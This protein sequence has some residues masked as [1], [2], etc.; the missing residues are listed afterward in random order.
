MTIRYADRV[1]QTSATTGT[2]AYLLG[3]VMPGGYR[4][5]DDVPGIVDGD[6][7]YASID[8]EYSDEYEVGLYT[9][10]DSGFLE[11][12][13]IMASSRDGLPVPWP[14]GATR[15]ISLTLTAS[16]ID[17]STLQYV[18]ASVSSDR[19]LALRGGVFVLVDPPTGG[20]GD[21]AVPGAPIIGTAQAGNATVSIYFSAPVSNGGSA[22]LD[23]RAYLSDGTEVVGS[24]SPIV[25]TGKIN[26]QPYTGYVRARNALGMGPASATSNTVTPQSTA[27]VPT[28][29]TNVSATPADGSVSV[30]FNVPASDGGS[31]ILDYTVTLS[32]GQTATGGVSP[33]SVAAP[34]GTP[35][36]AT[37]RARNAVGFS[38]PSAASNS[39][40]P[41]ASLAVPGAPTNVTASAGLGVVSVAFTAPTDTGGSPIIDYTV[42]LTTGQQ[43]T[44][45]SSPISV[46]APAGTPVQAFVRARNSIG[47]GNPSAAS[48][49]VTPSSIPDNSLLL[50]GQSL[51]ADSNF[52]I[53]A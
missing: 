12:T 37:V 40:T 34:N 25:F 30:A 17:P 6:E 7:V 27:T 46:A 23:Y 14:S 15:R 38:S 52:L 4:G 49:T 44:G 43:A 11:R 51:L 42:T 10:R 41:S 24:V 26:G 39:V 29:P 9:Y 50:D 35:V 13:T 5:F 21:V 18:G 20:G 16:Q 48:N 28:A 22:I 32:T 8:Q 33:I 36:T 3:P 45:A 53:L 19:V 2:G 31:A 47:Q 1:F